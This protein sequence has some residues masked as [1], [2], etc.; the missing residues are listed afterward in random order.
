MLCSKQYIVKW[1]Y[2]LTF[3]S[4]IFQIK[5]LCKL[6]INKHHKLTMH[7]LQ[8]KKFIVHNTP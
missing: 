4:T 1:Y 8:I 3:V 2:K 7:A 5:F 6:H